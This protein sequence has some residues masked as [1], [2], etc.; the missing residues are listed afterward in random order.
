MASATNPVVFCVHTLPRRVIA[1]QTIAPVDVL[2]ISNLHDFP[3]IWN[4]TIANG[5][6][7]TQHKNIGLPAGAT[8]FNSLAR[9]SAFLKV[10]DASGARSYASV[11]S[12]GH[13]AQTRFIASDTSAAPYNTT[14]N[15][16]ILLTVQGTAAD[17]D[18]T[19]IAFPASAALGG[20]QLNVMVEAS[21]PAVQDALINCRIEIGGYGSVLTVSTTTGNG[22]SPIV[23]TTATAHG[24]LG[25]ND[26]TGVNRV[27]IAS[28]GGNTNADGLF[29]AKVTGLSSNQMALYY[30]Q[31]LA[32]GATGNGVYT[33]GGTV[34]IAPLYTIYD[35]ASTDATLALGPIVGAFDTGQNRSMATYS[36]KNIPT[37]NRTCQ[38]L[39]ITRNGAA[40]LTTYSLVILAIASAG[41]GG[42]FYGNTEFDLAY[43]DRWA[44][45]ESGGIVA[46]DMG[47][48]LLKNTG[49]PSVV[50][51]GSSGIAGTKIPVSPNVLYDYSLHVVNPGT[52]VQVY[53]GLS[54][55]PDGSPDVSSGVPSSVDFYFRTPDEAAAGL[56]AT[57]W[58]TTDIYQ[59]VTSGPNKFWVMDAQGPAW[60]WTVNGTTIAPVANVKTETIGWG[61]GLTDRDLRDPGITLPS[62][63][64]IAM[65]RA[66]TVWTANQRSFVG[67][68]QD[69]AGNYC[70]GDLYF[71]ALGFPFRFASTQ[72]SETAASRLTFSG[73]RIRTGVMTAAGANGA[74][75]IY[76]LTDCSFNAL[77][78]AGGLVGG[79]YDASS[80][81]TRVRVNAHGTNEPFSVAERAGIIFYIDQE[82]QIIRFA[83]GGLS[84]ISRNAVDDK[85]KNIP[86]A[87]RGTACGVFWKDRYYL[88]YTPASGTA[89]THI[90]GW[91]DVLEEW[92]FDDSL[93]STVAAG[94]IVRTFDASQVGSGCRLLVFSSDGHVYGYEEGSAEPGSG[95][96]PSIELRSREYQ[97]PDLNLFR[98]A[99]SQIMV[100]AQTATLNLDCTYKPRDSVFRGTYDC[101]DA[102]G[103]PLAVK[104]DSRI[105]TEQTSTGAPENGWSGFVDL[106]GN[107]AC[108]SVLWRLESDMEALSLGAG[109]R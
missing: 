83:G 45:S 108:G 104:Q 39:K 14:G 84:S 73:E 5:P 17:Q 78:T 3:L 56:P 16:C 27:K 109:E 42:G 96:G 97:T 59:P 32:H 68:I 22:V 44:V 70:Y 67:A 60:L 81:S 88:A 69:P 63:Y 62:A 94:K 28:V 64:N 71:S 57:Y 15:T 85:T 58:T 47:A 35:S 19:T 30:D 34:M 101:S 86:A 10:G 95:T 12:D 13:T 43:T 49:G 76:V 11:Q 29:Y 50:T 82:G 99:S 54:G 48:D 87:L 26:G 4:P 8:Q 77:G 23:V 102:E 6:A 18:S 2:S 52:S 65:P 74:S 20:E 90:L 80:L 75:I 103:K 98:F 92:E 36:L 53:G 7:L 93:P 61:Y 24:L 40:T 91:N 105:R 9:L 1:G 31:A 37:T 72:E 21:T 106:N 46:T 66:A 107:L 89:N 100:D 33:S 25:A 38:Y 79:G 41:S 51:S 55:G